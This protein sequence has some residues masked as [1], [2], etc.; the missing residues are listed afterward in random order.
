M[1]TSVGEAFVEPAR[2]VRRDLETARSVV[3]TL[4]GLAGGTLEIVAPTTRAVDP[5]ADLAGVFRRRR[6]V[7]DIVIVEP[8]NAAAV[9]DVVRTGECEL[10]LAGVRAHGKAVETLELCRQEVLAVVP[11][12]DRFPQ[13]GP[14]ALGEVARM[15]LVA[16]AR[17][18]A[19]R[20]LMDQALGGEG[21]SPRIAVETVHQAAVV[22]LVLAGA[23]ATLL[24]RSLAE[25]AARRGAV[26]LV[27]RPRLVRPVWRCAGVGRSR[28]PHRRSSRWPARSSRA[29]WQRRRRTTSTDSLRPEHSRRLG[30]R[31]ALTRGPRSRMLC[32]EA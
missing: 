24:P 28:L 20:A 2:Q 21:R 30:S 27:T 3:R 1:P 16:T 8:P 31:R 22:P 23:G 7:I 11:R 18:T 12:S 25:E 6:P 10:G 4:A 5:L 19:T 29:R 14:V 17:G 32:C 26:A 15:D 13:A 9:A